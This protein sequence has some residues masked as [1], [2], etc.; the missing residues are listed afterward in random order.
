MKATFVF[1]PLWFQNLIMVFSLALVL[2][3][4]V[5]SIKKQKPRF[6]WISLI[7]LFLIFAFFNSRFWGFSSI[8]IYPE[9]VKLNYGILSIKK[10]KTLSYPV[11]CSIT[12]EISKIP[13]KET[14]YLVIDTSKS[15][16]VTSSKLKQLK[17]IC[18]LIKSYQSNL[19]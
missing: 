18:S 10:N 7:W 3:F 8:T 15:M 14:F 16:G 12:K 19:Q 4:F 1:V 17:Q 2:A 9:R 13:F 6:C 5:Y 11:S